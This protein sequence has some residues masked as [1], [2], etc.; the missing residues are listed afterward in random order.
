[1]V[2]IWE[3]KNFKSSNLYRFLA[4]VNQKHELTLNDY[5]SLHKWSIE[6][7]EDFWLAI[8]LFF[9]INF[10]DKPIKICD[11]Q[12]PFYKTQWF[13]NSSLSYST[14]LLRHAKSN[15][16]AMIYK[17]EL[18]DQIKI[19]WNSLLNRAAD[20]KN[21]LIKAKVKKGDVVVGYLLNHPDTIASFIATNVLGGVWSC[22]SPDFGIDSIVDRFGQ[23][24]PK[25]LLAHNKYNYNGKSFDQSKK[26]IT[27]EKRLSSIKKNISFLR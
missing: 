14:H 27:L 7:L 24:K 5:A 20:I 9:E 17:N 15:S 26:I 21:Q 16:L 4:Y 8:A 11:A 22:C 25:I 2:K 6:N 23:L 1:M 13:T 18:G 12:T 3:P 19:S 10:L